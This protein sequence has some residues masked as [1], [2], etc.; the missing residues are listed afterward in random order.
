MD[1]L[2]QT[3]PATSTDD[4]RSQDESPLSLGLPRPNRTLA[5]LTTSALTLPGIVGPAGADSPIERASAST[6]SSYYKE[7]DL[8]RNKLRSN[9]GGS[10]ERYEIITQQV[11]VDL[12]VS[13]RVDIGIDYLYEEMSG[14]SPWFVEA[15]PANGGQP[16]QV[17]SGATIEDARHDATLDLDYYMDAGKDTFSTGFSV[18]NDYTSMHFGLGSERNYND[19]NTVINLA[20][21]FSYDWIEPTD[22]DLYANRPDSETKWTLD[23]FASLSQILS[24]ASTIQFTVNYKH[25]EGYLSDPYKE[26]TDIMSERYPDTRPGKREQFTLLG[27]YR[28]HVE[29]LNGSA[30]ADY[31]FHVDNWGIISHA[32]EVAWHQNFLEHFTVAPGVRWYSQSQADFYDSVLAVDPQGGDASSDYRLS[33]YGAISAKL[34][35]EAE[36]QNLFEYSPSRALEAVG[37]TEGLDL[38]VGISY[39][40]YF[41]DGHLA[42]TSLNEAD[43]AP[44]LVS[45]QIFSAT[46]SGRF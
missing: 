28:H 31:Q 41:S 18:E 38:I 45:F 29:P 20:G 24:R 19:K 15:D 40:W 14:A 5:A 39:E 17:M 33:A 7:A 27:R 37:V 30:H 43:E 21:A 12:P 26:I 6:S 22:A 25:S 35:V 3:K 13:E 11:R 44:G 8:P 9:S 10:R 36:I 16:R 1:R 46:I 34:K 32:A 2:V 42:I 4:S 23:L